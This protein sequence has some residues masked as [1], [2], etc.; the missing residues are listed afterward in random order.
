MI[1]LILLIMMM[2]ILMMV[3]VIMKLVLF[4][5]RAEQLMRL[6]RKCR[7]TFIYNAEMMDCVPI[8]EVVKTHG[9]K[10]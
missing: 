1:E 4:V 7:Y 9:S 8:S 3:M 10:V 6:V 5:V 2:N